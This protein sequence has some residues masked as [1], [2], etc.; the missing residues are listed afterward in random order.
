MKSF[1][2]Q[3]H[4]DALLRN[5]SDFLCRSKFFKLPAHYTCIDVTYL[6]EKFMWHSDIRDRTVFKFHQKGLLLIRVRANFDCCF[7]P[8]DILTSWRFAFLILR[9]CGTRMVMQVSSYIPSYCYTRLFVFPS[10]TGEPL[11]SPRSAVELKF[12][13]ILT[14]DEYPKGGHFAAREQPAFL[15]ES[16]RN[17]HTALRKQ[18]TKSKLWNTCKVPIWSSRYTYVMPIADKKGSRWAT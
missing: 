16:I 5:D 15:A 11:Y 14:Y 7:F 4:F 6:H 9:L 2:L 13:N 1:G 12:K 10:C 17:F 18:Q 3:F 8:H